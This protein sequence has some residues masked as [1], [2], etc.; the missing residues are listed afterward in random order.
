M[1]TKDILLG[2]AFVVALIALIVSIGAR[3]D[4]EPLGGY[5]AGDWE[6]ADDLIA[7][8]DLTV[9]GLAT[10]GE[11]LTVTGETNLVNLIYG[12]AVTT[13]STSSATYTLTAAQIC[14]SAV[15]SYQNTATSSTLTLPATTTLAA[16]CLTADG[17]TKYVLLENAATTTYNATIAAGTG[18]T[19]LEPSG[20]DVIIAQNEWALIQLTRVRLAEYAVIVTSIQDAD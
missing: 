2:I 18:N 6:A 13:I 3:S 8:D 4:Y 9:A 11:T 12:G 1:N 17:D 10:I 15:I 16:D 14:D 7:G 5:T 19:L 20:G